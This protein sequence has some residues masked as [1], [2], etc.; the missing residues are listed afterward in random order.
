MLSISVDLTD[1]LCVVVGG[2]EVALKRVETLLEAGAKICVISPDVCSELQELHSNS[3]IN[4]HVSFF[5]NELPD[6]STLVVAATNSSKV[7]E[8]VVKYANDRKILVNNAGDA[9]SGNVQ[10]P[11]VVRRG[12]LTITITTHGASPSLTAKLKKE[13]SEKYGSEFEPYLELLKA[14]RYELFA[15]T[16]DKIKRMEIGRKLAGNEVLYVLT[17][18]GK[19][20]EAMDEGR[21]CILRALE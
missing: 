6:N 11:A 2:G 16:Q 9:T 21:S 14:L 19:T 18:Q 3:Q 10:F 12:D 20:N 17:K 5:K 7:N 13:I 4:W 1:K 15:A 8:A